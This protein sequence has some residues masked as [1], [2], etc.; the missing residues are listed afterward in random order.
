MEVVKFDN[1]KKTWKEV[2]RY[3]K[4]SDFSFE[5]EV[6]KKLLNIFHVGDYYYYVFNCATAS[7]EHVND[8]VMQILGMERP[9]QLSTEYLVSNMHP[10]DQPYFFDFEARVLDFLKGL[11]PDQIF[12]YKMSYDYRVKT[13]RGNYIRI[14]QQSV[15]IQSDEHGAVIRVLGVHTDITHLKREGVPTLSYIGLEGAPSY[16]DVASGRISP[17]PKVELLTRRERE[18]IQL[19]V[20]G[21]TSKEIGAALFITKQT[22]DGH[23]KNILRKMNCRSTI[24]LSLKLMQ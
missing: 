11:G 23:R 4:N 12:K 14:L 15:T 16:Y 6:H 9:D 2:A 1:I 20:K 3:S 22:V 10:E 7:L 5:M 21:K 13:M 8:N 24:E 19:L 18:V 17:D